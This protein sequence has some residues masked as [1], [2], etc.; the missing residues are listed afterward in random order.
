[1]AFWTLLLGGPAHLGLTGDKG[2]LLDTVQGQ[3]DSWQ[4]SCRLSW[5]WGWSS[6]ATPCSLVNGQLCGRRRH[7]PGIWSLVSSPA[8]HRAARLPSPTSPGTTARPPLQHDTQNPFSRT[9]TEPAS[10]AHPGTHHSRRL[11]VAT[12][13]EAGRPPSLHGL[14]SRIQSQP[15]SCGFSGTWP[16][17]SLLKRKMDKNK[18]APPCTHSWPRGATCEATRP[19]AHST[20]AMRNKQQR[21]NNY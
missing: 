3:G 10:E 11:L 8:I 18:R 12:W 1:M 7:G 21:K 6:R 9:K 20:R 16:G 19:T 17:L 13:G 2:H 15:L 14:Q 4:R 5:G